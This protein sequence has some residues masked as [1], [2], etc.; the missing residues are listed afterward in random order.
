MLPSPQRV[1]HRSLTLILVVLLLS[2][3]LATS[4]ASYYTAYQSIRSS[5]VDTELPLTSDTIYSEIQKDL[6]RPILI[7][8]MMARNVYITDWVQAGEHDPAMIIRYLEDVQKHYQTLT[9][10]F[11][12]DK[13]RTYYQAKG[14]LKKISPAA[15]RDIWYY[16]LK[17]SKKPYAINIDV[18]L[19]NQDRLTIF[20]NYKVQDQQGNFIGAT[21]VGLQLDTI[22]E[23]IQ[24]YQQRYK[25]KV[26]FSDATGRLVLAGTQGGPAGLGIGN[27]L[28]DVPGLE[29]LATLTPDTL[30][31][32]HSYDDQGQNHLLNVR[33]IPEL[34]W[35]LFVDKEDESGLVAIRKSLYFNLL[36]CAVVSVIIIALVHIALRRY[37]RRLKA[38][39]TTDQLTGLLNRRG[40][41]LLARQ[42]LKEAE[43]EK[44][45]LCALMLDID[46]F[47][48]LN[49][50]HGHMAGDEVLRKF[51]ETL[52]HSIREADI[53]C[54]WGGEEFILLLKNTEADQAREL[55][56]KIR[57]RISDMAVPFANEVLS[58]TT[59]LGL[60]Q[61]KA[62]E[63][64]E[65]LI[66]RA[67]RALYR[68]K[69]LGRN[70][71][72]QDLA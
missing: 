5:V 68:A 69:Q 64:I 39:A 19:A 44:S 59:S 26:F 72:Q 66:N 8:S 29:S 32:T 70:R 33:Y 20:I 61:L 2:G 55:G 65:Q 40:F 37:Q 67:D 41:D 58:V 31:A 27:L 23:H 7:S 14:V 63:N 46:R 28:S 53:L 62:G 36:I 71:L 50:S 35:Y 42:T 4:L 3:F 9:S 25:R 16:E 45:P 24:T 43:R 52:H 10:F 13:S 34:N 6:V 38:L 49:D 57:Q 18:D 12:S 60:A 1:S 54:R 48:N 30:Y 17:N 56:E 47:K 22:S 21:G 15:F 51:S 11:V